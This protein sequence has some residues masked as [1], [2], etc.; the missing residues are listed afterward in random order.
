MM[1][2]NLFQFDEYQQQQ[3]EQQS[4]NIDSTAV[5]GKIIS[6]FILTDKNF[7]F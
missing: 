1:N 7:D 3:E 2:G 5:G 4:I 6:F